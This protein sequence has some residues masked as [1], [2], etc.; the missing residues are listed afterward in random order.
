MKRIA[1]FCDGTWNRHDVAHPTNVVR[2]AQAVKHTATDGRK[3]EVFY[4]LGVGTGRGSNK[5]ARWLDRTLG[6]AIGMGLV[7]NINDAYRNLVFAYEPGDEIYIFGFS[8]GAYTA[9]SLA[10]LIRSC[11]IPPREHVHRLGEAMERYRSRSQDTHPDD[12]QSFAF[13]S[14]FA[15]FTATSQKE[16]D[17]RLRERPGMCVHLAINYLGVWDTVG[18]LGVPAHW[19]TASLFNRK[20]QFHDAHLS[21]MVKSARH[22]VA[23]DER[24]RTF[25]P[26]M[27]SDKLDAMNRTALGLQPDVTLD[28]KS[29]DNWAYRQEWFPG[30]HGSVGGGGDRHG[31]SSY[32]CDWIAQGAQRVGLEMDERVLSSIRERKN[33]REALTNHSEQS[34]MKKAMM[35]GARDRAGPT[36]V[37]DVSQV[38]QDR[39]ACDKAYAP[40]SLAHVMSK[41]EEQITKDDLLPPD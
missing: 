22:A 1:I 29:R 18:A 33:I 27:W 9:R 34:L 16:W 35:L 36:R 40:A 17:W 13:R 11:G 4:V 8:R 25:A 20:H 14:D 38:T 12:D 37:Q 19:A 26:A 39:I 15:P 7:E 5:A 41:I 3:Q 21:S 32:A 10:G 31:L 28:P 24:R 6:G 2:L 23:L 30:D